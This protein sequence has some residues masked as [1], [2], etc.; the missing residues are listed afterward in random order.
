M[1]LSFGL[2]HGESADGDAGRIERSDKFSGSRSKVRLNAALH[3]PEQSLVGSRLRSEGTLRPAMSPIHSDDA[4]SVVVGIGTFV[5]RH[6]DV[7]A[8]VLLNGNRLFGYE[9]MRRAVD[10]TL[11][12]HAVVIYFSSL[13]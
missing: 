12:G 6:D 5:E 13:R 4:V 3:D 9:A 2:A 8:E 7:R 10:V 1:H 11:E